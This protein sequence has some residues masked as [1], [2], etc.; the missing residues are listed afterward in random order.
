MAATRTASGRPG[1]SNEGLKEM[2]ETLVMLDGL[3]FP[4]S[5]RWHDDRI[6]LCNWGSGE[7]LAVKP[8]GESEVMAQVEP[9]TLPF[10]VDWVPDNHALIIDG[11]NR[12]LLRQESDA[13]LEAVCDLSAFS[14]KPYNELVVDRV[15]NA[16]INGGQGEI[17]LVRPDGICADAEGA[18]WVA[19]VPG[20]HCIRVQEGGSVLDTV[21]V[22]LGCFSCMLGGDV[23][24]T[25][26]VGAAVWRGMETAMNDGPG[27]TGQ[28]LAAPYQPAPHAGRP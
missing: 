7:V 14:S 27:A 24:R 28:L 16:Y 15:G 10:S 21:A 22:G 8:G 4:E 26:F 25:L 9:Q 17:V 23:G 19:S 12:R 20:E 11:P 18:I 1:C 5:L 3:G 13:R 2:S 6:W